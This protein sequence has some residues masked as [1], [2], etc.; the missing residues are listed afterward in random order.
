MKGKKKSETT[1]FLHNLGFSALSS[2]NSKV[3]D[4]VFEIDMEMEWLHELLY[5][6]KIYLSRLSSS[7]MSDLVVVLVNSE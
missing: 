4:V 2:I 3:K 7:N 1:K 5:E 6:C